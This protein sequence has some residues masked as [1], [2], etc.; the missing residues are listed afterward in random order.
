[1][2]GLP[3]VLSV[4][5]GGLG[6]L[7]LFFDWTETDGI[8]IRTPSSFLPAS[9]P[10]GAAADPRPLWLKVLQLDFLGTA[11]AIAFNVCLSLGLQY[12]GVERSWDSASVIVLLVLV[13]VLGA[14]LV[15]WSMWLGPQRAMLPVSLLK[16]RSI[17]GAAFAATFGWAAFMVR[18]INSPGS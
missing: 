10:L 17:V 18:P 12:G 16:R 9:P 3:V 6:A 2:F 13:P 4:P 11:I 7:C 5:L 1:V 15:G 8:C 14:L